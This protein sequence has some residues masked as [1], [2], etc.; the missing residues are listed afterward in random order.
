[1]TPFIYIAAPQTI[2]QEI[3][4]KLETF[5]AIGERH[6]FKQFLFNSF[7]MIYAKTKSPQSFVKI[8]QNV[9]LLMRMVTSQKHISVTYAP[10]VEYCCSTPSFLK[11]KDGTK[12]LQ[13]MA[14]NANQSFG[15]MVRLCM[16][17]CFNVDLMAQTNKQYDVIQAQ[18]S[19]LTKTF[20]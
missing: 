5:I 13:V 20:V 14:S 17:L 8:S 2:G 19:L 10:L 12:F 1:M 7:A 4:G 9:N 11:Q 18:E 15:Y 3:L 16:Q 6:V